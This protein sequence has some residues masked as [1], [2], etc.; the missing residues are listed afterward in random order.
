MAYDYSNAVYFD[1][2]KV[3]Q[4]CP[5]IFNASSAAG[6]GLLS[7]ESESSST[8]AAGVS[9]L[10]GSQSPSGENEALFAFRG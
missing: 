7:L 3:A 2:D 9:I 5:R 4:V 10:E 1:E 8:H 6:Y